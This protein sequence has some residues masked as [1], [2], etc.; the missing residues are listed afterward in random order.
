MSICIKISLYVLI[1]FCTSV[2][3]WLGVALCDTDSVTWHWRGWTWMCVKRQRWKSFLGGDGE[4]HWPQQQ[5]TSLAQHCQPLDWNSAGQSRSFFPI[6]LWTQLIVTGSWFAV[7]LLCVVSYCC[8]LCLHCYSL[9]PSDVRLFTA[10]FQSSFASYTISQLLSTYSDTLKIIAVKQQ[11][12]QC[13]LQIKHPDTHL[14]Q[15][16]ALACHNCES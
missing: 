15:S 12:W 7:S 2:V 5:H 14:Y 10:V 6:L 13:Y 11:T 4:T 16:L 1:K 3:A 9:I 8:L